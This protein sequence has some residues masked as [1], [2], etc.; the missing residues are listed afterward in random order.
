MPTYKRYI[1][2][3]KQTVYFFTKKPFAVYNRKWIDCYNRSFPICCL[4]EYEADFDFSK[5]PRN[6]VL[7]VEIKIK[8]KNNEL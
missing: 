8:L 3:D 7:E 5:L 6:Q 2:K 1:L 4:Q